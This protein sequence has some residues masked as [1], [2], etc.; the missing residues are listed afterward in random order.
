MRVL[1]VNKYWR[2]LGGVETHVTAV[3]NY[4]EQLGHE[5]VPFAMWEEE[6][7]ETPMKKYF[8]SAVDFR[9]TSL[10]GSLRALERSIVS[11]ETRRKLQALLQESCVDAA[12]VVHVYH[13]LGTVVLNI[14]RDLGIPTVLSV[15]DYKLACPNY[16]LFSDRTRT[17]C[18]RCL[19]H[20]TG[21][22]WAPVIERCWSG[23]SVAG[24]ALALEAAAT[25]MRRSYQ[26]PRSVITTNALQDRAAV[27]AGVDPCDIFRIPHP[28]VLQDERPGPIDGDFVVIA[29][30]VP[31]KGVDIAVKAA[32][33][34][35]YPLTIIGDGRESASLHSLAREAKVRIVFL[36]SLPIDETR[37]RLRQ[38][39]ALLVP[40]VWHEVSPLVVYD[41]IAADVPVIGTDVGG[42][43]DLLENGR[44]HLVRPADVYQLAQAMED[45]VKR[46]ESAQEMSRTA[47]EFARTNWSI[48]AWGDQLSN[49]FDHAGA[50]RL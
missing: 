18:T 40:S 33:L 24:A 20:R 39:R 37:S 30:L 12:Y 44:G 42:I 32:S 13:Q 27:T 43:S 22:L 34:T 16:R 25:R 48:E 11:I 38:A 8:P 41:A 9:A 5:V 26:M 50:G 17:I 49:A 3:A 14:L 21:F 29:R 35:G 46:P 15:H 4:L 31:E 45:V 23:S 10:K 7:I 47:R 6:T 1:V 28:V 36:G 19:D 2:P